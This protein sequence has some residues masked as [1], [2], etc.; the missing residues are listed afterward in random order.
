[1]ARPAGVFRRLPKV[2]PKDEMTSTDLVASNLFLASIDEFLGPR[3]HRFFGEGYKRAQHRMS[4]IRITTG[5]DG[6]GLVESRVSVAYPPDWSRKGGHDQRP[7][8]STVDVIV[9]GARLGEMYLAHARGLDAV[10]RSRSALRSVRVRA[11]TKPVENDLTDLVATARITE[12]PGDLTTTTVEC[13]VET[14][15]VRLEIWHEAGDPV[16][17]PGSYDSP[18]ELLG[19]PSARLF[20]TG[21]Q[22]RRQLLEN[23]E[24][25]MNEPAARASV[26]VLHDPALPSL[27]EGLGVERRGSASAID[28]FVVGLQ[29]GQVLLYA[30][31]DVPR[32]R[33]D[34]LWMRRTVLECDVPRPALGDPAPAVAVLENARL[35]GNGRG[36]VWR[37]ADI[38]AEF[39]GIRMRCSV[40]HRLS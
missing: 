39:H 18:E 11:G 7:H 3:E 23:V 38:V 16:R 21:Y 27:E 25:E 24:A 15:R 4:A 30:L 19:D 1:M 2:F 29:L 22:A 37:S 20:G 31:D 14:M 17:E 34:T 32:A 36:E 12:S 35:L 28:C 26:R 10:R 33:S 13:A 6:E 40:A 8:L 5:D 9:I